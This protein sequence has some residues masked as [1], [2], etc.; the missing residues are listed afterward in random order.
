MSITGPS[1]L[2]FRTSRLL[3]VGFMSDNL[4]RDHRKIAFRDVTEADPSKGEAIYGG[5]G[6]GQHYS[7]ATWED[8]ALLVS[9]P[10]WCV[11]RTAPARRCG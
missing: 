3:G 4:I 7:S 10:R 1:D 6:V 9:G 8:R 5:V 11:S 2:T